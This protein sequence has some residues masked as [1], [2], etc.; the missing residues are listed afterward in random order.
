MRDGRLDRIDVVRIDKKAGRMYVFGNESNWVYHAIICSL[1]TGDIFSDETSSPGFFTHTKQFKEYL[2]KVREA[3]DKNERELLE[4]RDEKF[5]R[6]KEN[7][8]RIYQL[9]KSEV[10]KELGRDLELVIDGTQTY[11]RAWD[12]ERI[13]LSAF[14]LGA[15]AV[16]NFQYAGE[17]YCIGT[18][19]RFKDKKV[20]EEK[21]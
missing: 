17:N 7:N 11:L 13:L 6:I 3:E 5:R 10:E 2:R 18:P 16:V 14:D 4:L 15:D 19:V 20:E 12:E 9:S 1:D 21:E 8:L